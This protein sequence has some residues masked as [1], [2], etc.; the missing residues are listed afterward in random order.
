MVHL[1][2]ISASGQHH[3][4][5]SLHG[6]HG[7]INA[8]DFDNEGVRIGISFVY[9]HSSRLLGSSISWLFR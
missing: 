6:S 9:N 3:K 1:W 8:L 4:Y 5:G 7:A 2:E